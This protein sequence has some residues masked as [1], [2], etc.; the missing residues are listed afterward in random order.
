MP[1]R[2]GAA[3]RANEH[4][5]PDAAVAQLAGAAVT[6]R[7]FLRV[8]TQGRPV[9]VSGVTQDWPAAKLWQDEGYLAS[10]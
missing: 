4:D 10:S 7:D 1:H 6:P 9:V 3:Q 2:R 5:T 8:V